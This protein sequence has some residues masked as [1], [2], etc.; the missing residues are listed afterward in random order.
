VGEIDDLRERVEWLETAVR[1][2]A[3]SVSPPVTLPAHPHGE[4]RELSF[5]VTALLDAGNDMA[6]IQRYR[7]ETGAGLA[8]AK[9]AIDAY[10]A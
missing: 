3:G 4:R 10:R 1:R 5:E 2:V 9:D 7:Q 8:E 6:A